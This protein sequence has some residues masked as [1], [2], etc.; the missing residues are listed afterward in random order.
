MNKLALALLFIGSLVVA[1]P[2]Q[3]ASAFKEYKPGMVKEALADGKTVFIDYYATWCGTCRAQA[4]VLDEILTENP[5]YGDAMLLVK[6][7][8]DEYKN[9]EISTQYK[10]PRR[11]TLLL[12]RG[13]EELG[14]VVAQTSRD[15]IEKLMSRGL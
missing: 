5:G 12:L 8:W 1:A 7:N 11:S 9:A 4:R 10:I 14:R 6:V 13:N 3:A 15:A 2:A